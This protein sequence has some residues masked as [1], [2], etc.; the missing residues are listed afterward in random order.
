MTDL[1]ATA[2]V[3]WSIKQTDFYL[4]NEK[5]TIKKKIHTETLFNSW[6]EKKS[7]VLGK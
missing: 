7:K 3:R 2:Y 5:K 1:G 4:N 6:K